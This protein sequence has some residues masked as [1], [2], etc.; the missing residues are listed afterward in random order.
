MKRYFCIIIAFIMITPYVAKS[1]ENF[2]SPSDPVQ[3]RLFWM[4]TGKTMPK[5]KFSVMDAEV[6]LLQLGYAPTNFAHLNFSWELPLFGIDNT[7]WSI[8]S[9]FQLIPT[10][11]IFQGLAVGA[12]VGFF[13]RIFEISSTSE[14][15]RLFSVNIA[16]SFGNYFAK[17]HIS[18]SQL[19][20]SSSQS[21][22]LIPTYLQLGTDIQFIRNDDGSGAKF[23]A[24]TFFSRGKTD[25]TLNTLII[26]I[27][28][29]GK[30][31][32]GE[33]GWPFSTIN[34]FS[35][36]STLQPWSVPYASITLFF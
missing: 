3:N 18:V 7:Y 33:F 31:S 6:F 15:K 29:F 12:D 35:S 23:I 20:F 4:S 2:S 27:R 26:G 10:S 21:T 30:G 36:S 19:Q 11:G 1:Q 25:L 9:K 13:S 24:E 16:A 22:I 28:F 5:G 32:A 34:F 14:S 17:A 8:G